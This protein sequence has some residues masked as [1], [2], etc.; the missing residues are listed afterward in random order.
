MSFFL[1][2]F[3]KNNS[4][5]KYEYAPNKRNAPYLTFIFFFSFF[6]ISKRYH[7]IQPRAISRLIL[8]ACFEHN[9]IILPKIIT[10]APLF[11]V[12]RVRVTDGGFI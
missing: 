6:C 8:P 1:E 4:P 12:S 3:E 2:S 9:A 11:A 7:R 10:S 5:D